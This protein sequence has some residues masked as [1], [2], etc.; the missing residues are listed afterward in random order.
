M[1]SMNGMANRDGDRWAVVVNGDGS[2]LIER[3][4]ANGPAV[5]SVRA[6]WPGA[7]RQVWGAIARLQGGSVQSITI[8]S[9]GNGVDSIGVRVVKKEHERA[10]VVIRDDTVQ[11]RRLGDSP[12][13]FVC[14]E[15][16]IVDL[17]RLIDSAV[18]LGLLEGKHENT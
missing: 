8:S 18:S 15:A 4:R 5:F 2:G 7:M 14:S 1:I 12:C 9:S 11:R 3:Q 6:C 13:D 10:S 16:D 17:S